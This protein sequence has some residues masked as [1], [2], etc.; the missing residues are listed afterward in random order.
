MSDEC[1][2]SMPDCDEVDYTMKEYNKML[3]EL[4]KC[5]DR[6]NGQVLTNQNTALL[7]RYIDQSQLPGR[8]LEPAQ[9]RHGCVQLLHP[10]RTQARDA[11]GHA[12]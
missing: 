11:Q 1:L 3:E 4:T 5:R 6:L 8:K 10:Q 2:L 7:L 12:G 9:A